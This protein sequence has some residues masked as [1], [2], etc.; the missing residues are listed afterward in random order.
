MKEHLQ[1]KVEE[2]KHFRNDYNGPTRHIFARSLL[3]GGGELMEKSRPK[4]GQEATHYLWK[5][6]RRPTKPLN[7]ASHRGRGYIAS[8]G[9]VGRGEEALGK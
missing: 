3:L 1:R 4:K 6:T 7:F 9:G 8:R 2:K 5:A